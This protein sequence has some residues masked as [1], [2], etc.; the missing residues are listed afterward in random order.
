MARFATREELRKT[1]KEAPLREYIQNSGDALAIEEY[2]MACLSRFF[3][4]DAPR[5][6]FLNAHMGTGK[7]FMAILAVML[8][9]D[10]RPNSRA[11][12][13]APSGLLRSVWKSEFE[14]FTTMGGVRVRP[15]TDEPVPEVRRLSIDC[16]R[17]VLA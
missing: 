3:S 2:Q 16:L 9:M 13:V 11:L 1:L 8:T 7:T 6:M 4:P 15:K 10:R 5:E 17:G 14:K 12:V